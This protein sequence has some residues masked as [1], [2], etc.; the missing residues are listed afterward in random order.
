MSP[1]TLPQ[2]GTYTVHIDPQG[3]GTGHMSLDPEIVPGDPVYPILANGVL[4]SG[5]NGGAGQNALFTFTGSANQKISLVV[6]NDVQRRVSVSFQETPA[7]EALRAII[8]QAGLTLVNPP[9]SRPLPIVVYYQLPMDVNEAPA[10]AIS[11]RFGV[12]AELAKW[13][14]E[15]RAMSLRQGSQQ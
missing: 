6:S 11:A 1:I 13:L 7:D 2:N 12:S 8:A 5:S 10:E 9:A 14:V 3:S 15:S 4:V